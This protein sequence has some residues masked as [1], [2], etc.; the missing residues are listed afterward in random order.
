MES[1]GTVEKWPKFSHGIEKLTE[2]DSSFIGCISGEK[3]LQK[4]GKIH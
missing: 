1:L 4:I 3:R 2:I